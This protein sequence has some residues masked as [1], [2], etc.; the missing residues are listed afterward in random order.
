M[1]LGGPNGIDQPLFPNESQQR[2]GDTQH[3]AARSALRR[4]VLAAAACEGAAGAAATA[5]DQIAQLRADVARASAREAKDELRPCFSYGNQGHFR[6]AGLIKSHS[7]SRLADVEAAGKAAN[8]R[9]DV[10]LQKER[11]ARMALRQQT[12]SPHDATSISDTIASRETRRREPT[13]TAEAKVQLRMELVA[14]I[15][16]A[17][18]ARAHVEVLTDRLRE[19]EAEMSSSSKELR[20]LRAGEASCLKDL[21]MEVAAAKYSL[22]AEATAASD[23]R[24]EIDD[25]A[26]ECRAM[27]QAKTIEAGEAISLRRSLVGAE[28]K[29]NEVTRKANVDRLR[30]RSETDE[31][32][33]KV[34]ILETAE[35]N[36]ADDSSSLLRSRASNDL[37][38]QREKAT[39]EFLASVLSGRLITFVH[40]V[41]L[42]W[43]NV[44]AREQEA[45]TQKRLETK[46]VEVLRIECKTA[47]RE[48]DEFRNISDK[49]QSALASVESQAESAV[50]SSEQAECVA[51]LTSWRERAQRN[52]LSSLLAAE[53]E[54]LLR[55]FFF[56]WRGTVS[57]RRE[58][59]ARQRSL[60]QTQSLLQ[61]EQE[62][63]ALLESSLE[64]VRK[65]S[66][67]ETHEA[68]ACLSESRRHADAAA[69]FRLELQEAAARTRDA[70]SKATADLVHLRRELSDSSFWKAE[71][72][73]LRS[74]LEAE[75]SQAENTRKLHAETSDCLHVEQADK[76][77]LQEEFNVSQ[78]R[79][80]EE[81]AEVCVLRV[82][83]TEATERSEQLAQRSV[84]TSCDDALW[85]S[86][87]GNA[88][89]EALSARREMGLRGFV[90]TLL[91]KQMEAV[92]KEAFCAWR[93]VPVV[94]QKQAQ[95]TAHLRA[96]QLAES[97]VACLSSELELSKLEREAA[98]AAAE[99]QTE[100]ISR[101]KLGENETSQELKSLRCEFSSSV[102]R[103]ADL[104]ESLTRESAKPAAG[105]TNPEISSCF[106]H[107]RWGRAA[108]GVLSSL[109]ACQ[110]ECV[111]R[112]TFHVWLAACEKPAKNLTVDKSAQ[113]LN[114]TSPPP[115]NESGLEL[116]QT[117]KLVAV[118]K[119]VLATQM[120][121]RIEATTR[122]AFLSWRDFL[123]SATGA[124][125]QELAVQIAGAETREK[126][127][128]TKL[129]E[130][131]SQLASVAQEKLRLAENFSEQSTSLRKASDEASLYSSEVAIL[132]E[133]MRQLQEAEKTTV[134]RAA[135]VEARID[136]TSEAAA[137]SQNH[138]SLVSHA[139]A[140]ASATLWAR[141][142]RAARAAFGSLLS[143]N[144]DNVLRGAFIF[145]TDVLQM[146][147]ATPT[148]SDQSVEVATRAL[149]TEVERLRAELSQSEQRQFSTYN[150]SKQQSPADSQNSFPASL[151]LIQRR[152]RAARSFLTTV[153]ASRL[154][155]HVR[156]I[157]LLWASAVAR[158]GGVGD[159]PSAAVFHES[160]KEQADYQAK[161]VADPIASDA[162]EELR[163]VR[164][165]VSQSKATAMGH[166]ILMELLMRREVAARGLL[167][168]LISRLLE[169]FVATII[170]EWKAAIASP[171]G[172]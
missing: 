7:L 170:R 130:V 38:R 123:C 4:L 103:I 87:N 65:M 154:K 36:A 58:E 78:R 28:Q 148:E 119:G 51:V 155:I 106:L 55:G 64:E 138:D 84:A 73:Q 59:D 8:A 93:A 149:K 12:S 89:C 128:E 39:R 110:L 159:A 25:A 23:L 80:A 97:E 135:E 169:D 92:V 79:I 30:Y 172:R 115:G 35:K 153:I 75:T 134:R 40:T 68:R 163:E 52:V 53:F 143:R 24:N 54:T 27:R 151:L 142:D 167:S 62:T 32:R 1:A 50:I 45:C 98:M 94:T 2:R 136:Q 37:M 165:V 21:E 71:V 22:A 99:S 121:A 160:Q 124:N 116:L 131:Q 100:L 127:A 16:E 41:F 77:A 90:S 137:A 48:V 95:E 122:G 74:N 118:M 83:A 34:C 139:N 88:L 33:S 66:E 140:T 146:K 15:E 120:A 46:E 70:D 133:K 86:L 44:L 42:S 56:S 26:A 67:Q 113:C 6:D 49:A 20:C 157:F 13:L 109:L 57:A 11:R 107:G 102:A 162:T 43:Q 19:S 117:R 108:R 158:V 112:D 69:E 18:R 168:S 171:V 105:A 125:G 114:G 141:R 63:I 72:A 31:L 91:A 166:R 104:E 81:S 82:A 147:R 60:S 96:G 164:R 111:V 150:A 14:E 61:R 3:T 101:I 5:A 161:T 29:T 9:A 85:A 132:T 17:R 47:L 126:A 129:S 156:G 10:A 145:W 152:E 76:N 144:L